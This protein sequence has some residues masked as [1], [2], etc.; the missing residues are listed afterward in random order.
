MNGSCLLKDENEFDNLF[1]SFLFCNDENN[2]GMKS[3]S[4]CFSF[5]RFCRL[6]SIFAKRNQSSFFLD[7]DLRK[8]DFDQIGQNNRNL[9][10]NCKEC[11][12]FVLFLLFDL[13]IVE[14]EK[15]GKRFEICLFATIGETRERK[16]SVVFRI[17]Q[18]G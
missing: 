18:T 17:C 12:E 3:H 10:R 9:N 7:C 2:Q 1:F 6:L 11:F 13:R 16:K 15:C 14:K 4:F 5:C 8:R